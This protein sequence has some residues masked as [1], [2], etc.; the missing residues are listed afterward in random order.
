MV[1]EL[2]PNK[3]YSLKVLMGIL[4]CPKVRKKTSYCPPF[5]AVEGMEV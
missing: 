3:K 4:L 2:K 1:K 5:P